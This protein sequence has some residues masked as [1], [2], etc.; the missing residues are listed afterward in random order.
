MLRNVASRSF[1]SSSLLFLYFRTKLEENEM[2]GD[3]LRRRWWAR[4]QSA[5]HH[6]PWDAQTDHSAA[7]WHICIWSLPLLLHP[8]C[9]KKKFKSRRELLIFMHICFSLCFW[10]DSMQYAFQLNERC[11]AVY[12][13][14]GDTACWFCF[15]LPNEAL[16][17]IYLSYLLILTLLALSCAAKHLRP[18]GSC[19]DNWMWS[20]EVE[21]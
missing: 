21:S 11:S 20:L 1:P 19:D 2:T 5:T 14:F 12:L 16:R 17:Y 7:V 9:V 8:S 10:F 4:H 13:H 18:D 15:V 3:V 6:F